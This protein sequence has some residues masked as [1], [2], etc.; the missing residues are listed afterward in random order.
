MALLWAVVWAIVGG[1]VMEGIVD[2]DGAILDM[3]PQTLALVGF[4]GGALFAV[5]LGIAARRRRF[6]ELSL[7]GFV[8]WG[9][10]A[11]LL[12]GGALLATGA[13]LFVLALTTLLSA[14]AAGGSL[15]LARRAEDRELLAAGA[16][17]S[18]AGLTEPEAR[19]LLGRRD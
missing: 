7:P 17:V 1:G 9:L 5:V 3:W 13:P 10:A 19:E 18:R 2:R 14:G 11:G 4:A 16:D 15:L 6:D 8:A 12:L